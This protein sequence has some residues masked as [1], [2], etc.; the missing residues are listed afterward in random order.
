MRGLEDDQVLLGNQYRQDLKTEQLR[1]GRDYRSEWWPKSGFVGDRG[2]DVAFLEQR[3]W[4]DPD[5]PSGASSRLGIAG[6]TRDV[7]GTA[8]GSVTCKL[9]RTS[10][11]TLQASVLSDSVSGQYLVSTP[12]T[13]G[14]YVVFYKTGAPDVYG[15]TANTLLAS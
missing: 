10:D 13:D 1:T 12:F 3:S 5:E 8:L 6:I 15:T 14:H 9:F 11:D 4:G 7:Y 2:V